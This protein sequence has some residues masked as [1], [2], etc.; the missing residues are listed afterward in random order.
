MLR[1]LA[2]ECVGPL[3]PLAGNFKIGSESSLRFENM[4]SDPK[5]IPAMLPEPADAMISGLRGPADVGV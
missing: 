1:P 5:D 2:R 3:F 4:Y